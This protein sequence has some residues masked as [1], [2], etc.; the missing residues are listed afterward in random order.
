MKKYN[1][2]RTDAIQLIETII[3][4]GEYK[5]RILRVHTGAVGKD[6]LDFDFEEEDNGWKNDCDLTYNATY[7]TWSAN[8]HDIDKQIHVVEGES[9]NMNELIVKNEIIRQFAT[10]KEWKEYEKTVLPLSGI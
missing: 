1:E 4:S 9:E 2:T 7:R 3:Q 10:E 6:V 8:L 5:G